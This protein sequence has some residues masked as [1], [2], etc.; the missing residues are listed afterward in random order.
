M[1]KL[2]LYNNKYKYDTRELTKAFLGSVEERNIEDYRS[3]SKDADNYLYSSINFEKNDIMVYIEIAL[4]KSIYKFKEKFIIDDL[5]DFETE[6]KRLYKRFLFKSLSKV[7]NKQLDWGILTGVRPIK[8]LHEY[9]DKDLDISSKKSKE[10]SNENINLAKEF[11]I[12]DKFVKN[13]KADLA[14]DIMKRE[15]NIIYPVNN[16]SISI[17]ISIPFCPSRCIYC[18]FPSNSIKDKDIYIRDYL[19]ALKKELDYIVNLVNEKSLIVDSIYI[20]GGTPTTLNISEF[21]EIFKVLERIKGY[22]DIKE[23]TVEAGRP[24]TIDLEKLK[25]LKSKNV[26]R[27]SINPQTMNNTTLNYINRNHTAEDIIKAF[28][29]AR[30]VNFRTI[31]MDLILGLFYEN[32]DLVNNT[33]KYVRELSPENLTV[34]TLAYKRN[35]SISSL[36][37]KGLNH[38]N[39]DIKAMIEEVYE[40]TRENNYEPY[41]LY[42]QKNMVG[43][44]E[45]IGYTRRGHK[46][47]YNIKIMSEKQTIIAIGA[48]AVSKIVNLEDNKVIRLP[49]NK[50]IGHYINRVD[51]SILKKKKLLSDI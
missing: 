9:I 30:K 37:E 23:F 43:N 10:I 28:E 44:F 12:K 22:M 20:G 45:N 1:I 27:I 35:A 47:I 34:H 16:K 13:N 21:N 49:N 17:Y 2:F 50:G 39:N 41:Y 4:D 24:D 11:L 31:N 38:S 36:T 5:K 29:I 15:R 32:L 18:S 46:S 8:L 14:I 40:F 7:S 19:N 33:L 25:F 48:G 3:I 26:D 6:K 51:E 42:R